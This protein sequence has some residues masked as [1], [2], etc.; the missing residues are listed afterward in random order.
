MKIH[1][2]A[3]DYMYVGDFHSP[4]NIDG[5]SYPWWLAGAQSLLEDIQSPWHGR[6]QRDCL[7]VS[8]KGTRDI[9]AAGK[10]RT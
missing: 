1:C 8:H 6:S 7:K 10:K 9:L 3:V 4:L 2:G 5:C